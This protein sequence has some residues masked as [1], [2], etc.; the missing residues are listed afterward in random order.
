MPPNIK[1][2][3]K[4]LPSCLFFV[5]SFVP[6]FFLSFI[7]FFLYSFLFFFPSCLQFFRLSVP[8]FVPSFLPLFSLC[9]TNLIRRIALDWNLT[10]E[11]SISFISFTLPHQN[12]SVVHSHPD[13]QSPNSRS[14]HVMP[15][16]HTS[17]STGSGVKPLTHIECIITCTPWWWC[18][19]EH[20]LAY[21]YQSH[22]QC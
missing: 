19:N 18:L 17:T 2:K 14:I 9:K 11:P 8:L 4:F 12:L 15:E 1:K 5:R 7:P 20:V 21:E 13:I 10:L 6:F 3:K 22:N 16:R